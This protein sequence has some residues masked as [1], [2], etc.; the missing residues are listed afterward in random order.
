M[1][2]SICSGHTAL[3]TN[4]QKCLAVALDREEMDEDENA[5]AQS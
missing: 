3:M 1:L 5:E 2:S 4:F